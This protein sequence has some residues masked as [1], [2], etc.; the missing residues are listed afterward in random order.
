MSMTL[1]LTLLVVLFLAYSNGSNDNFKGV[2]TLYGSGTC[3]YGSALAWATL[4]TLAGSLLALWLA[5]GLTESFKGKGLVPDSVTTQPAFLVAVSLGA[6]LTVLLA[7][8]LGLPV[9]T[10]HALTGGLVGAGLLASAGEMH[11]AVLGRGFF[12]PLL[13][14]PVIA[15]ALAGLLYPVFRWTR[16]RFGIISQ[17]CVCIGQTFEEVTLQTDGSLALVRTGAVIE[18]GQASA[19]VQRYQGRMLGIQ[20]GPLLDGLHYLSGGAVGFARGLNDTPKMVALLLA[21]EAVN[22]SLGLVLVALV[23]ASGGLL[24]A[25]RVADTM[26]RKITLMNPGQ[27]FTANLA[28]SL[29]VAGAS[30]LGLPVSTTHVAVSSLF[31]IGLVNRTANARMIGTILLAWVT[32]LPLG[33]ALAAGVYLVLRIV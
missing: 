24:N 7:T 25:R 12:L 2:A 18:V 10:T 28:T 15:L 8:R 14:S 16:R 20:A 1:A 17:S 13:L 5:R 27:G 26:S 9:S 23:M 29:L 30:R 19:C 11:F 32:T 22:P 4:T 31:G 3:S 21:G 33:A 6:A